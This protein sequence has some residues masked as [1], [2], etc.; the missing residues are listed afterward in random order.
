[1]NSTVEEVSK[2]QSVPFSSSNRGELSNGVPHRGAWRVLEVVTDTGGS[3]G[4]IMGSISDDVEAKTAMTCVSTDSHVL[5][6]A[7]R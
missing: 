2:D 7:S 3:V 4:V 1:M 6:Q 5:I